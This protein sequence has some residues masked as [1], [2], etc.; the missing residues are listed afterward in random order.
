MKARNEKKHSNPFKITVLNTYLMINV[1]L[2]M[3]S[4]FQLPFEV[5][6]LQLIVTLPFFLKV[7]LCP[8]SLSPL[9]DTVAI[10]KSLLDQL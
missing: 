3:S 7:T 9:V 1:H 8:P 10:F 6:I 5:F 4:F 2:C